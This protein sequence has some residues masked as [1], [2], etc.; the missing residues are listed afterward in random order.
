MYNT[1]PRVFDIIQKRISISI[2]VLKRDQATFLW[3]FYDTIGRAAFNPLTKVM[4]TNWFTGQHL[5]GWTVPRDSDNHA[6]FLSSP[7]AFKAIC[8]ISSGREIQA[9]W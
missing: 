6:K 7:A 8:T 1:D 5:E 2:T 4:F 9:L 3:I